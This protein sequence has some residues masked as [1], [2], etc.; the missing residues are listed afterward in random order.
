MENSKKKMYIGMGMYVLLILTFV[1][2]DDINFNKHLAETRTINEDTA[3]ILDE[4]QLTEQNIETFEDAEKELEKMTA[5]SFPEVRPVM[6]LFSIFFK[7]SIEYGKIIILIGIAISL[8]FLLRNR[9]RNK[10][11]DD[12]NSSNPIKSDNIQGEIKIKESIEELIIIIPKT[13]WVKD[14]QQNIA[15]IIGTMFFVVFI[16][17]VAVVSL[18]P[19]GEMIKGLTDPNLNPVFLFAIWYSFIGLIFFILIAGFLFWFTLYRLTG[20]D[21]ISISKI[22]NKVIFSRNFPFRSVVPRFI[23]EKKS[24]INQVSVFLTEP[25]KIFNSLTILKTDLYLVFKKSNFKEDKVEI[26]G[27]CNIEEKESIYKSIKKYI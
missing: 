26:A 6:N 3:N 25:V 9:S 7:Y 2:I 23:Y 17:L 10:D 1:I 14:S 19:N 13:N 20:Y 18:S 8:L 16:I 27:N 24:D 11:I 4:K 5:E 22:K 12:A 15:T 21:K